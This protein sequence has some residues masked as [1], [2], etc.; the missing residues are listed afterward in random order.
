MLRD[1]IDSIG[2][3]YDEYRTILAYQ[4]RRISP[5]FVMRDLFNADRK[6]YNK[7]LYWKILQERQSAKFNEGYLKARLESL[8]FIS[9]N[10]RGILDLPREELMEYSARNATLN[11]IWAEFGVYRGYSLNI[12][13]SLTDKIVHGFDSFDGLPEDWT[14]GMKKGAFRISATDMLKLKNNISLHKGL[15]SD[16]LP[17]FKEENK[18]E[19]MAFVHVDCDLYSSTK[20]VFTNLMPMIKPGTVILFDEYYQ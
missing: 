15:F 16:T 5:S 3:R 11:G 14:S 2:S 17:G 4:K 7:K 13:A 12:I 20:T 9:E 1:I 6:N 19:A 18:G 10:F 8:N